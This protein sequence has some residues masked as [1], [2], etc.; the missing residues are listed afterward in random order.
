MKLCLAHNNRSLK[1]LLLLQGKAS[2][3]VGLIQYSFL[4]ANFETMNIYSMSL[5]W[6]HYDQPSLGQ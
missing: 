5:F 3:M 1:H 6:A 4:K 2:D